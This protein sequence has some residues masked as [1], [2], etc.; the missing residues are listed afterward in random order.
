MCQCKRTPWVIV[1]VL[2]TIIIGFAVKFM[3][4]GS[5]ATAE[6]GRTQVLLNTS[7]R[8]QVL[9]EMRQLLAS[10]QQVV[11][12][13]SEQ[14]LK[15]VVEAAS[16]VGMQAT[17]TMD[18]TLKAKLP[19]DFKKLGFATHQAFD[20]IARMAQEGKSVQ[21]IQAKLARTMNQCVACH[22]SFQL[23]VLKP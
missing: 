3:V 16:K 4:L 17:S 5:T 23:P 8:A 12:G 2:L 21:A 22:A 13:L 9:G 14:D 11:E 20:D 18:V 7:E 1:A 19:M 10:T 6:D 15:K